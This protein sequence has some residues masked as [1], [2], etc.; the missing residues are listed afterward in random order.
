MGSTSEKVT[1][2][3][4]KKYTPEDVLRILYQHKWL[5]IVPLA[6]ATAG[7]AVVARRMPSI[8]KSETL[9]QVIPQRIPESYVR[10]TVTTRLADRLGGIQQTIMSRSHLERI[11]NDFNLYPKTG[12]S[13]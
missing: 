12:R 9:I 8:Y 3:P 7:A 5:I 6:I 13:R 4:G 2:L 11:I 1:V 10:S